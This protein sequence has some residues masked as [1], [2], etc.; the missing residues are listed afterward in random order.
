MVTSSIALEIVGHLKERGEK[1]LWAPDRYLGD[2]IQHETGADMLMWQGSCIVHEGFKADALE[3]MM[4]RMPGAAVLV[5]PESP[6]GVIALADVVGSTTALIN[7]VR[8]LP[9]DTL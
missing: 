9:N 3:E 2:Y 6:P 4:A 7:A 8:T 5:H 1:I